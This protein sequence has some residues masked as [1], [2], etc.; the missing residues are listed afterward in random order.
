MA[1]VLDASKGG[2]AANAYATIDEANAYLEAE[3]GAE[4]W[5]DI[6]PDDKAKL[7]VS[8]TRMLDALPVRY[9]S[10]DPAQALSFPLLTNDP[11][12]DGFTEAKT[13]AIIQAFYIYQNNDGIKEAVQ[14][15]IQGVKSETIGP[16]SK[17]VTGY[18]P[19]R[20][21]DSRVLALIA[22]FIDLGVK[23]AR[24]PVLLPFSNWDPIMK[25]Y[26]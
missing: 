14:M 22:P 16:T 17:G 5:A 18:N 12:I 8:A 1:I 11:N 2:A 9:G 6:S 13:A 26:V 24:G 7:L 4:E 21:F 19:Y 20:K 25:R 3:Y 10:I 23:T 15:G